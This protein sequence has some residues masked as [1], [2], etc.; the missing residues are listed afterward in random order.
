MAKIPKKQITESEKDLAVF[1]FTLSNLAML[2]YVVGKDLRDAYYRADGDLRN[3]VGFGANT[4]KGEWQKSIDE[5]DGYCYEE[6]QKVRE[7]Y[8]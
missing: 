4:E 2:H 8:I 7:R 1:Y 5:G 3:E 6:W